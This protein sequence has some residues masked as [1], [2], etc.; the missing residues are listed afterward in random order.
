MALRTSSWWTKNSFRFGNERTQPMRKN[1]GGGPDRI[2]ATSHAKSLLLCQPHPAPLGEPLER[3]RE[4]EAGASDEIALTQH[5]VGGEVVSGPALEQ[6]GYVS[7]EFV[8]EIAQRKALL[9]VERKIFHI[10]VSYF[11]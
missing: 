4:H 2:R 10:P 3:A 11:A 6:R 9:R 8:E 1:P 5:D 7:P